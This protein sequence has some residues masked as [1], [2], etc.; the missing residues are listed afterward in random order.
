MSRLSHPMPA[1]PTR[2]VWF[3]YD[4]SEHRMEAPIGE[5]MWDHVTQ[6]LATRLQRSV[7]MAGAPQ[8]DTGT[9]HWTLPLRV[10]RRFVGAREVALPIRW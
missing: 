7:A 9:R 3:T 6:A 2:P 8:Y 4:G 5:A 1:S 10:A